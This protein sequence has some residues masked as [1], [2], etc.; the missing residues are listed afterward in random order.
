MKKYF[1]MGFFL[2]LIS[3]SRRIVL[4]QFQHDSITP[5]VSIKKSAFF[6]HYSHRSLEIWN[7]PG[8]ML[9]YGIWRH[10]CINVAVWQNHKQW[11]QQTP[12][13]RLTFAAPIIVKTSPMKL[14]SPGRPI[15]PM[16]K[17]MKNPLKIGIVLRSPPKV[18][19]SWLSLLWSNIPRQRKSALVTIA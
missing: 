13:Q 19:I 11:Y 12:N 8:E 15:E 18:P 3:C 10:D 17:R 4:K 1:S 14:L 2:N 16:L 5:D 6:F 9:W 7:S